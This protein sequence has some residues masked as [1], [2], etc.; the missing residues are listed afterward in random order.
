M[1]TPAILEPAALEAL[2][3]YDTPTIANAIETLDIRPRNEG[4]M[5]S[6]VASIFPDLPVALGYAVTGRIRSAT[7][8]PERY[9]RRA[10]W[11]HILSVPQPRLVVLQDLDDP[12]GR[13]AFWGEVQANIHHA[14]GCVGTITNGSVRDLSEA[15]AVPF[16]FFA[17][18]VAVSHAYVRLEDMGSEVTISGLSIAS[19][20]LLMADRHGVLSVP[21]DRVTELVAAAERLIERERR[22]IEYCRS[23]DFSLDGLQQVVG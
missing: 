22:I 8:S 14:L 11:E 12:P 19:G 10:W 5:G 1:P 21:M 15:E 6:D 18:G 13:G 7:P 3:A 9:P 20:N 23:A 17:G 16:A 2:R 4:F